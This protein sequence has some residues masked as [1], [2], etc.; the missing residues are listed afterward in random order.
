MQYKAIFFDM[1]GT[2]LPMDMEVFTNGYFKDL[3]KKLAKYG[4][5]PKALIDAVWSGTAAMVKND[6]SRKNEDAFW[7]HFEQITNLKK[8]DVN[9]DCLDFYGNEFKGA[10]IYVGENPLAKEAVQ[11]A[12]EKA[13]IVALTTNPIFP[14]VGQETRM[15]WLGLNKEDF[16]L[17]TSYETDVY[18]K[19]NPKYF[20]DVCERLG[21]EPSECLLIGNDEMEDMYAGTL[22]GLTCY[23]VTDSIVTSKEHPWDG[24]RGTFADMVEMLRNLN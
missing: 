1:D 14:M 15:G 8:E 9:A 10:N 16:D 21:V 23:L 20:L 18:C 12:H 4:L 7:E 19:P 17:V 24:D 6:G 3:V 11:L 22:A 13:E 5:E 2:L